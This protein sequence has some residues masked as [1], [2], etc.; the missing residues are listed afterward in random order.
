[1][2][3]QVRNAAMTI[4]TTSTIVSTNLLEKQR[5]VLV[6][7]NTSIGGQTITLSWGQEAV[8]NQGIVLTPNGSWSES[9]DS[10]FVP[11]EL[12]IYGVSSAAGGTL[13]IHERVLG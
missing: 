7:I 1:M 8:A 9:I 12:Q 5:R 11:N 3:E 4:G 13:S 2:S 6:L 10:V